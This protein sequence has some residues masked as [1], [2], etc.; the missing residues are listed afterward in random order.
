MDII[1]EEIQ[2]FSRANEILITFVNISYK[3][4]FDVWLS[5][6]SSFN[7]NNL[8]VVALDRD[9]YNYL[10]GMKISAVLMDT[11]ELNK[12]NEKKILWIK[13]VELISRLIEQGISVIHSDAD[14]FW[15]KDIRPHLLI[16]QSDLVFSIAYA[17]PRDVVKQWGF[18]LCCGFFR[19]NSN[20]KTR[21]FVR[22]FLK[23]CYKYGD[24]QV[25]IN[26]LLLEKGTV[27]SEDS[28][29]HNYGF[30]PDYSL[31]IDVL[32]K[33][34]VSRQSNP[35]AL[36]YHPFLSSSDVSEKLKQV[37]NGLKEILGSGW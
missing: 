32:S 27:W 5:K 15:L 16:K 34:V 17:L 10:I 13:R 37:N 6:I 33:H 21:Y 31:T 2:G 11:P 3:P 19:I 23:E 28:N 9:I 26:K 29:A 22:D 30:C 12:T 36:V 14:A 18:I 35:S 4:I 7:I 8:C 20:K 1:I 25:A 24:D